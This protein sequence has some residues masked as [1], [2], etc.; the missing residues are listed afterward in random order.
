MAA[1]IRQKHIGAIIVPSFEKLADKFS[2]LGKHKMAKND[3]VI[4]FLADEINNSL[5]DYASYEKIHKFIIQSEK[6]S[7]ENGELTPKLSLRRHVIHERNLE[8]IDKIYKT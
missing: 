8:E 7:I 2:V 5:K 3:E 1:N 6:F 4:S